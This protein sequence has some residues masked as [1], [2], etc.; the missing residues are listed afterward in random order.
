MNTIT[1]SPKTGKLGPLNTGDVFRIEGSLYIL[2]TVRGKDALF[3]NLATGEIW[4][5]KV[6]E[7][8]DHPI[9]MEM[10]V[11]NYFGAFRW[12]HLGSCRIDVQRLS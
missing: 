6:L 8:I 4:S 2:A 1:E 9:S 7:L 5:D 12:E 3:A 10:R 11:A